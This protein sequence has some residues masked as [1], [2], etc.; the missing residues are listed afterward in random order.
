MSSIIVN[1][2]QS[3]RFISLGRCTAMPYKPEERLPLTDHQ[4]KLYPQVEQQFT[5]EG[6][7][8]LKLNRKIDSVLGTRTRK[9]FE[10]R[11]PRYNYKIREE[12]MDENQDWPSM[13]PTAK[14]F[15][16]SGVPLPLRQSYEQKKPPRGKY[17]N[18]ELLKIANF[19]HLTPVA[20]ERQCNAIKKFCTPWPEGLDKDEEVR[21]YF[22]ITYITC[23]YV[24]SLPTIRDERSRIVQLRINI[25]DLKLDPI[26]E[27]KII[28]LLTP[29]RYDKQTGQITITA[30]A[31]PSKI[32]NEDY[33]NYLLTALY[34]ES[35]KHEKWEEDKPEEDWERFYWGKSESKS[36]VKHY[37]AN[38]KVTDEVIESSKGDKVIESYK[39]SLE[40]VYEQENVENLES[41]RA[42]VEKL[43]GF[44]SGEAVSTK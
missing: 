16:P 42:S 39:Q 17:V 29:N 27:D 2:R 3:K 6:Y 18:T 12:A 4:K 34:F 32:Q 44:K 10:R 1:F 40:K 43:L 22:P 41:Y 26:D 14:T 24:H 11:K 35:I 23:D 5:D 13:W 21:T 30:S 33:S 36:K 31:C 8:L 37:Y 38:P 7:P 19:L 28:R 15:S 25:K 9:K 20:I